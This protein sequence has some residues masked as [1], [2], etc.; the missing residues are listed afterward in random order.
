MV[1]FKKYCESY[2]PTAHVDFSVVETT[3]PEKLK[4]IEWENQLFKQSIPTRKENEAVLGVVGNSSQLLRHIEQYK[5]LGFQEENM[6]I[7]EIQ[8]KTWQGLVDEANRLES[9]GVIKKTNLAK[10][11]YNHDLFKKATEIPNL[12]HIDFDETRTHETLKEDVNYFYTNCEQLKTLCIVKNLR[13]G[14]DVNVPNELEYLVDIMNSHLQIA[15]KNRLISFLRKGVKMVMYGYDNIELSLNNSIK[16]FPHLSAL[17][18][19]YKRTMVSFIFTT[20]GN[21]PRRKSKSQQNTT[22]GRN[23]IE[24]LRRVHKIIVDTNNNI[25]YDQFKSL[26]ATLKNEI[27]SLRG[28]LTPFQL[29][30]FTRLEKFKL[31]ASLFQAAMEDRYLDPATNKNI[32]QTTYSEVELTPQKVHGRL[33]SVFYKEPYTFL[34]K[35][36]KAFYKPVF[37][38]Y[39]TDVSTIFEKY[40]EFSPQ[41]LDA[42]VSAETMNTFQRDAYGSGVWEGSLSSSL[43][44]YMKN[45]SE[46]AQEY[47]YFHNL[48]EIVCR[49]LP[50][51]L[52]SHVKSIKVNIYSNPKQGSSIGIKIEFLDVYNTP[53]RK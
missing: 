18:D 14:A 2:N 19:S 26:V 30:V 33:F 27:A 29:Y 22:N 10:R 38:N 16:N 52:G 44:R 13:R 15:S 12:T 32:D 21:W 24:A 48:Y 39:I 36:L 7:C 8:E 49:T 41:V 34:L 45:D 5:D 31:Y 46:R 20:E 3:S 6:Y 42:E 11:I 37:K 28:Q 53:K 51:V 40:D 4:V 9:E 47:T 17:Y 50:Y 23:F 1:T 35:G 43:C 25:A